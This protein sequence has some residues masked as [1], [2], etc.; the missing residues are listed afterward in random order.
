MQV[1]QEFQEFAVFFVDADDFGAIVGLQVGEEDGALFA[2]LREAAAKRYSVRTGLFIGETLE[3]KSFDLWRDSVLEAF[4]LIVSFG[5]GEADDVG[6]QHFGELMAEGHT[7]GDGAAFARQ[8][9]ATIASYGDEIVTAHA[10]E[11]GS[12]RGR[13]DAE[14][15]RKPRADGRLAFLDK[16]PDG[17]EIVFLGD[18]GFFTHEIRQIL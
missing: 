5:P 18:A 1:V 12:Y 2:E 17:F 8:V 15:L 16:F 9:D 4:R 14:F 10:F 7:F 6:K 3:E 11:G 13:S